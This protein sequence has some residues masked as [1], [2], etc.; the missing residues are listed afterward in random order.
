[1]SRKQ[2]LSNDEIAFQ[3]NISKRTVETHISAALTDLR[4]VISVLMLFF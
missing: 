4:K 2:G 1:M 3:L